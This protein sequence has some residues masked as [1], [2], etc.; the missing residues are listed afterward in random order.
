M[1]FLTERFEPN[2]DVFN[3]RVLFLNYNWSFS[4]G[5]CL[6][7]AFKRRSPLFVRQWTICCLVFCYRMNSSHVSRTV[8]LC[9]WFI[10]VI[11]VNKYYC[12]VTIIVLLLIFI[13]RFIFIW[14]RMDLWILPPEICN[15][16]GQSNLLT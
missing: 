5:S 11:Y 16:K 9:Y 4:C 10:V 14:L 15:R 7:T 13:Q 1:T 3:P 12:I 2:R 8:I 6:F